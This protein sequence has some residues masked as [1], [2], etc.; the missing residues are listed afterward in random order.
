MQS[1]RQACTPRSEVLKSD[2]RDTIFAADFGHVI[3]NRADEVYNSPELFFRNTYPTATLKKIITTIY[4]RLADPNEA[5]ASLRLSTGFGGGKTHTLIALWHLGKHL[6]DKTLGTELLPAAGRPKKVIVAG[7]DAGKFGKP[8]CATH[9]A[10][11]THSL[12]GELAYQL[13]EEPGY[14]MIEAVDQPTSLPNAQ[15][16]RAMLPDDPV[17]ILMDE[18]VIYM[19]TLEEQPQNTILAFINMLITEIGAHKQAVLVITDPAGQPVYQKEAA[20]LADVTKQLEAASRMDDVLGRK[21]SHFD[22][23]GAEAA[24]VIARRLF[25]SVNANAAQ[26]ASA[27]Y[28]QTY[29]RVAKDYPE[30]LPIEASKMEYSQQIV[31]CYPFH[32]RLLETAQ[33]RLRALQDFNLSR[34]TLRLF[35]RILRD[36]WEKEID[37]PLVTAGDINWTSDRIQS[38]LLSRLNRDAFKAA[39]DADIVHHASQLDSDYNTDAHR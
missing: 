26:I 21:L 18:L 8:I 9:G 35:A 16:V 19:A 39:V 30:I 24:R 22:P 6:Q 10:I 23:I 13:G 11:Q 5:G 14:R 33:E 1:I 7:I 38:D 37:L 17:L 34:G 2:L 4:G 31:D 32:P 36:I 28:L 29:Q 12:W 27:E 3:E 20:A 25:E 15:M